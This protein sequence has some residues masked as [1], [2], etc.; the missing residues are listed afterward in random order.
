MGAGGAGHGDGEVDSRV[1]KGWTDED[2]REQHA[3][4]AAEELKEDVED[5]VKGGDAAKGPEGEGD[6]GVHVR[7]G[8]VAPG[9]LN[10]GGGG[11]A[12]GEAHQQAAG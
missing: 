10:D 12:H 8:A 7:A 9:R 11:E 5:G 2:G 3:G 1:T 6:G 4:D